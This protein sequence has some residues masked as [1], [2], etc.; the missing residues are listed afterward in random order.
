MVSF[1]SDVLFAK[2]RRRFVFIGCLTLV[3]VSIVSLFGST[4]WTLRP[5][6][7]ALADSGMGSPQ[8]LENNAT[9]APTAPAQEVDRFDS[10][11]YLRG[12]PTDRFRG[13][14]TT[15]TFASGPKFIP[16]PDNLRP[17]VKYITSWISA[18]WSMSSIFLILYSD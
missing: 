9:T 12:P 15:P 13:M 2:P 14:S 3:G 18:G 17:E 7:Y 6:T 10:Q 1:D 4:L 5:S 16:R 8:H 11:L